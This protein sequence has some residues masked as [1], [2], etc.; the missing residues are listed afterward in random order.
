MKTYIFS[1]LL[2]V[3]LVP[4]GAIAQSQV[5]GTQELISELQRQKQNVPAADVTLEPATVTP[6]YSSDVGEFQIGSIIVSEPAGT[7]LPEFGSA[8]E[9]FIGSVVGQSGLQDI[10]TALASEARK[11]G[12]SFA[13]AYIPEQEIALGSLKVVVDLGRIDQVDIEGSQNVRLAA[14][15]GELEGRYARKAEIERK[16]LL[17]RD[18]P[19]V[20]INGTEFLRKNGRGRLLVRTRKQ[21]SSGFLGFDNHGDRAAGPYRARLDVDYAGIIEDDDRISVGVTATPVDPDE[22]TFV[23]ARY[24]N[25]LGNNGSQVWLTAAAGRTHENQ[26]GNKWR[27]RSRY[28]AMAFNTPVVRS[29]SANLWITAE[30]AFLDVDQRSGFGVDLDD[31]VTTLSLSASGNVKLAG[32]RLSGGVTYVRG[33]GLFG[34]TKPQDPFSS[35]FDGSG[36][37]SKEQLW[38]NWFGVLGNGFSMRIAGNG[39]IASRP[40][41]ASQEVGLG[42]AGYGRAYTFYERS[43]DEGAMGLFELRHVTQKPTKHVDWVQFYG[44]MDGGYVSN[45][46]SGFGSGSLVSSGAG[47]R[48]GLGKAEIGMEVA[49]PVNRMR[50]ETLNRHPRV[51]VSIGFRF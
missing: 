19:G 29:N 14:M 25:I 8:I 40:L 7:V 48:V 15:L 45:L 37:F 51:N 42:G 23:S 33:I 31:H 39:Q 44:F 1:V 9:P 43:G 21:Q 24:A 5:S 3:A 34:A 30:A 47:M 35:R 50:L 46:N 16:L 4:T 6:A 41:L 18:I 38:L 28:V 13:S 36:V 11:R 49:V 26:P 12:Y 17:A 10:A 2:G 22:L 32:G 27:S 20:A